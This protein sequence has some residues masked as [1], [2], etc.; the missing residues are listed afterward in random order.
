MKGRA[1]S[2]IRNVVQGDCFW[3]LRINPM[4]RM[5]QPKP[6]SQMRLFF[7]EEIVDPVFYVWYHILEC[8]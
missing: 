7:I 8:R 2:D 6:R 4:T 3:P 5:A 1:K